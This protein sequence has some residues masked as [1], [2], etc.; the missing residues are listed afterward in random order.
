MSFLFSTIGVSVASITVIANVGL[1]ASTIP[2]LL[3]KGAPYMPTKKQSLSLILDHALPQLIKGNIPER[4][5]NK[6]ND[7]DSE[8]TNFDV[9][10][11]AGEQVP[12]I[13]DLGSGDGRV[14]I[15]AARRGYCA[16]G[17]EINPLLVAISRI[18]ATWDKYF[19]KNGSASHRRGWSQSSQAQFFVRDL[20]SL[21]LSKADVIFCYGLTPIMD[22]L[23]EK[24]LN[25]N[26][27]CVVVCN[28]F[29]MNS[30][31]F[32]KLFA[33][34]EVYFYRPLVNSTACINS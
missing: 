30:G 27:N 17:Y 32:Q 6:A 34:D 22:R 12:L 24:I 15:A 7:I 25:E 4:K 3:G 10:T 33:Q 2:A 26:K 16:V 5:K 14:V 19:Y 11:K 13:Y 23:G 9:F 28:V 18:W 21:D 20:W 31:K 29:E 1:V 8:F